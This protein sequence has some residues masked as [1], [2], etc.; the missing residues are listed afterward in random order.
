MPKMNTKAQRVWE[1]RAK[2][3]DGLLATLYKA[4]WKDDE[5]AS[6]IGASFNTVRRWRLSKATPQGM[7]LKQLEQLVEGVKNGKIQRPQPLV[8]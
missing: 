7:R 1:G 2:R 4:D 8:A 6:A 3:V 5:I